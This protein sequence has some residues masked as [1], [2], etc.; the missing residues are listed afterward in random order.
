MKTLRLFSLAFLV[1]LIPS[2]L[3]A[4]QQNVMCPLAGG[5]TQASFTATQRILTAPTTPTSRTI[6]VNGVATADTSTQAAIHICRVYMQIVQPSSAA[7]YSLVSGTGTNCGTGQAQLTPIFKGTASTTEKFEILF[8]GPGA[9]TVPKGK[10]V[11]V[12]LATNVPTGVVALLNY[13]N[14]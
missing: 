2:G 8:T 13:G 11:C 6:Y 4:Q 10:D 12:K 5:A 3:W 14:W 9:L 1:L 7:D